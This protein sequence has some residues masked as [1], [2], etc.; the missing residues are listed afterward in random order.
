M[1]T[2]VDQLAQY[3]AYHRDGR[4]ILTHFVGVP[5]IVLAVVIVLSRPAW[6]LGD[7]GFVVSPAVGAARAAAHY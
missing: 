6:V 2:L 5:L 7:V 3:A 4:N 1:K